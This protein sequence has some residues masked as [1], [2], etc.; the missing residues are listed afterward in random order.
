MTGSTAVRAAL[1]RAHRRSWGRLVG[2]LFRRFG[3]LHA[4]E[5]AVAAAFESA[6]T[7]WAAG[8]PDEPEA[9]LRVAARNHLV[10]TLR[11]TARESPTGDD[12][13]LDRAIA[14]REDGASPSGGDDLDPRVGLLLVC[15]HPA[16]DARLHAP[17]MMQVVLGIDAARIA[18]LFLTSPVALGQR[19]ARGKAKIRDAGIRFAHPSPE[20]R[21]ARLGAALAAV[22]AAYGVGGEVEP[23]GPE[24]GDDLRAEAIRLATEVAASFPEHAEAHGLVA[25]LCH[26]ESRRAGREPARFV[27]LE[28]QDPARWS[29][30]WRARGDAALDRAGALVAAGIDRPGRYQL[31]AAIS[32]VHSARAITGRTDWAAI[33]SLYAVLLATAPTAGAVVAAAG[34]A[35]HDDD[36]DAARGLL[37]A[38]PVATVRDYQPYWVCRAALLRAAASEGAAASAE[39]SE[40]RARAIGLTTDPAVRAYLL[41]QQS[42]SR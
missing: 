33:R 6:A 7:A 25:L 15:A 16:I 11:R 12:A 35:L 1:E 23:A 21:P 27:P 9:W 8:V 34:A 26:S 42:P 38:L 41:R 28:R 18:P 14:P 10:S 24:R 29:P 19:L 13:V 36:L 39:E 32:A 22:Y 40:A 31:E 37:D 5:D 4:A 20:Q 3:D 17:L 30:E 2:A